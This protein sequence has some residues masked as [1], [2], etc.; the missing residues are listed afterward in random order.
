M[1]E[2]I[3]LLDRGTGSLSILLT[4][5]ADGELPISRLCAKLKQNRATTV[6]VI[7]LLRR[8]DLVEVLSREKFPFSR[9]VRLS[10]SGRRLLVTPLDAWPSFFLRRRANFES[11]LQPLLRVGPTPAVRFGRRQRF[12]PQVKPR[13]V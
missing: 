6:R 1:L 2:E 5:D 10:N 12:L 11:A 8:L 9:Q 3:Y 13:A 4:L 7:E